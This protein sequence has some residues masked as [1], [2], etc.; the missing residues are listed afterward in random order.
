MKFIEVHEIPQHHWRNR[1]R[2]NTKA[3]LEEFMNM[4]IKLAKV[5]IRKGEYVSTY[6]AAESLKACVMRHGFP[7]VVSYIQDVVYIQRIDM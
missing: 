7:I 2:N 6:S 1:P 4:N 3:R 5:E